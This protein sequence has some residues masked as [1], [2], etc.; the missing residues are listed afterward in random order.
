MSAHL[1]KPLIEQAGSQAEFARRIG[2]AP[3][4][5]WQWLDGRRPVSPKFAR[6]IEAKFG[7]SRHDLRPDIFGP[8]PCEQQ[9]AA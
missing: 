2:A 5:V 9:E 8:P 6:E 1:L 7:L 3:A 4:L